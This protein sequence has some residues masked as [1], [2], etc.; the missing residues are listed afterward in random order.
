MIDEIIDLG[1]LDQEEVKK[2]SDA[3]NENTDEFTTLKLIEELAELQEKL[4]KFHLKDAK[5]KP[6]FKEILDEVGDVVLRTAFFI[7][8]HSSKD[9]GFDIMEYL[10]KRVEK[11]IVKLNGYVKE[12]KYKGG[13]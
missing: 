8:R 2:L 5:H 12:G 11:K 3:L 9:Y 13:L 1:V 7:E 4:I 6:E 10:D